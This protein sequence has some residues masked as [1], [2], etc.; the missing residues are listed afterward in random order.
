MLSEITFDLKHNIFIKEWNIDLVLYIGSRK[1]QSK[2]SDSSKAE[3]VFRDVPY[4]I[5]EVQQPHIDISPGKLTQEEFYQEHRQMLPLGLRSI[6]RARI[7]QT[8][9]LPLPSIASRQKRILSYRD[10]KNAIEILNPWFHYTEIFHQCRTDYNVCHRSIDMLSTQS[11]NKDLLRELLVLL[12]GPT[13]MF[14]APDLHTEFHIFLSDFKSK[15]KDQPKQIWIDLKRLNDTFC[16][17]RNV[18]DN[19]NTNQRHPSVGSLSTI[20]R[21]NTSF[22]NVKIIRNIFIEV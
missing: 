4:D 22:K 2:S 17:N 13:F 20:P 15:F 18:I 6:F 8:T 3:I 5:L 1:S 21:S 16:G 19:T 7:S 9:A 14:T 12:Y 10:T 11:L